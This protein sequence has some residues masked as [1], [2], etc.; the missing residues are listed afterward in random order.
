MDI[1]KEMDMLYIH[2]VSTASHFE[3]VPSVAYSIYHGFLRIPWRGYVSNRGLTFHF[4]HYF[5]QDS[6]GVYYTVEAK[7]TYRSK[8]SDVDD[9]ESDCSSVYTDASNFLAIEVPGDKNVGK[10]IRKSWALD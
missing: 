4:H 10:F 2:R 9:P 1:R 7:K 3:L 5:F 6:S 8:N